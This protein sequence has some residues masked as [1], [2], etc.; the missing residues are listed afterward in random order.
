[1][2]T[3]SLS[4]LA[5][6]LVFGACGAAPAPASDVAPGPD[7]SGVPAELHACL[8]P[9]AAVSDGSFHET[10]RVETS[11]GTLVLVEELDLDDPADAVAFRPALLELRDGGCTAVTADGP[12]TPAVLLASTGPSPYESL[13]AARYRWRAEAYGSPSAFARA[14]TEARRPH[15]AEACDLPTGQSS[16]DPNGECIPQVDAAALRALGVPIGSASS[17]ASETSGLPDALSPCLPA[18][19]RDHAAS[20]AETARQRTGGA[21][22]VLIEW[23][24]EAGGDATVAR[25]GTPAVLRVENGACTSLLPPQTDQAIGDVVPTDVAEA[26][27]E[28]RLDWAIQTLGGPSA[29]ADVLRAD[30]G[31]PLAQCAGPQEGWTACLAPALARRLRARGVAVSSR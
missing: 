31:G 27:A 26:F 20:L 12:L 29:Y 6:A 21:D 4:T 14:W 2:V 1:M 24:A 18:Y 10:A 15:P 22:Y 23:S 8:P 3:S 17:A 7:L 16:P 25:D 9:Y 28:Q 13:V 5:A 11:D 19:V 30:L